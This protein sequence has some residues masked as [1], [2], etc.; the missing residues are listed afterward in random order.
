MSR[1]PV[2]A[3]IMSMA[4]HHTA[5]PHA[6]G[7]PVA[8]SPLVAYAREPFSVVMALSTDAM[9]GLSTAEATTRLAV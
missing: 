7:A 9:R 5:T 8:T 6:G 4:S 2:S 3:R 1:D